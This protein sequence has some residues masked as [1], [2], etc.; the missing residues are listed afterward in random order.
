M[1]PVYSVAALP[2]GRSALSGS[3]D[4]TLRLWDIAAV[5]RDAGSGG[6]TSVLEGGSRR[7]RIYHQRTPAGPHLAA[8]G[9]AKE[10]RDRPSRDSEG[11]KPSMSPPA[12][13][14]QGKAGEQPARW[15][16]LLVGHDSR[17]LSVGVLP[18]GWRALSGSEDGTIRVWDL[19]SGGELRRLKSNARRILSVAVLPDGR[20]AIS[21]SDDQTL[22]LW[23]LDTGVRLR[24]LEGRAGAILSV[25][26]LPDE[27]RALTGSDAGIM[28]LWD[29]ENGVEL[30]RFQHNIAAICSVAALPDGRRALSGSKD[31]TILP[32][33][34]GERSRVAPA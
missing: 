25:A 7:R 9:E 30:R 4:K 12:P 13:G 6:S 17:V 15:P 32:M 31:G 33:G 23:D 8:G 28:V 18:D 19:K 5:G 20:R 24:W 34:F 26:A 21:G 1:G 16:Q 27:G 22:R 14:D 10:T 29:L 3:G 2:D 11:V